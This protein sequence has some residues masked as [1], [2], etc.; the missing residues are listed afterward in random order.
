M[1]TFW[2]CVLN[3]D[4]QRQA[5]IRCR[6]GRQT[7]RQARGDGYHCHLRSIIINVP[8][9]LLFSNTTS[10]CLDDHPYRAINES[11]ERRR[12]GLGAQ[13]PSADIFWQE[14][15]VLVRRI[16]L[17]CCCRSREGVD[18]DDDD[19]QPRDE[20]QPPRRIAVRPTCRIM[21]LLLLLIQLLITVTQLKQ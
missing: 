7:D 3:H 8:H 18:E 1:S 14:V 20:E 19:E 17:D 21:I 13:R 5:G 10:G 2:L 11:G 9:R 12:R 16:V 6:L 4:R 15:L